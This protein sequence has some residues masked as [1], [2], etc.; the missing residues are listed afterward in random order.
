MKRPASAPDTASAS[1]RPSACVDPLAP[2]T[3]A[4]EVRAL[5]RDGVRLKVDG[6]GRDRPDALLRRAGPRYRVPLFDVV[7]YLSEVRQNPAIRFFVAYVLH[8]TGRRRSLFARIFYK[9][10]S[11]VWRVASHMIASDAEFWIGKGD[12]RIEDDGD[13]ETVHSLE[14]TTDLPYEL[15]DA[16]ET[17]NQSATAVRED[18]RSVFEVLRHAPDGRVEPYA[19]FVRPRRAAVERGDVVNGGRRVARFTR[20]GD[21]T[22]L[23]FARG[24]EPDLD[25][26]V[27]VFTMRSKLYGGRLRRH[28]VLSRNRRIQY[29]FFEAPRH[30]W[31][32]PPQALSTE[33]S[34]YGVR[35]VDVAADEDL[36]V[37]GYE[38]HYPDP[39]EASGW[40]SQIPEG[41]AGESH[42][43]DP[44]RADASAWLDRLPV[45]EAFRRSLR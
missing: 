5:L 25:A 37:P 17:L 30:V 27:E 39:D 16:L 22:S 32:V 19:D 23:V 13:E 4:A 21:P 14:E 15:Q 40:F 31:I 8:G 9:D 38:Y 33:L 26:V 28:R 2:R 42:P 29:L 44:D 7:F 41:Y 24:F 18:E 36:F 43:K 20:P 10:V 35:V 45:V 34:S 12:V 3:V 1:A 6:D 11:L